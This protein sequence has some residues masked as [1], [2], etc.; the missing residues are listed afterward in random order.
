M[1]WVK[2]QQAAA[3]GTI[4]NFKAWMEAHKEEITAL[5]IFYNQPYRRRELT[6]SMIKDLCEKIKAE[7]PLLAPAQVWKAY[8]QLKQAEGSAKNELTALVS[9]IRHISGIDEKLTVYDKTVDKNFQQWI[10]KQNAGE[11]NRFTKEQMQWLRMIKDYIAGSFH[12]EKGDFELDPFNKMGGLGKMWQLF[13]EETDEII[14][15]LN[16]ALSA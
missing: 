1:G 8:E 5:Q 6:Y 3:E 7:Q 4:S 15:E 13:G 14:D 16:Q 2:D 11:H 10:L 9:M 12:V